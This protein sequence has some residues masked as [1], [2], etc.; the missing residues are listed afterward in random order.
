M[1]I[2]H[3]FYLGEYNDALFRQDLSQELICVSDWNDASVATE[4]TVS[5][6]GDVV[7]IAGYL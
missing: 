7:V 3:F 6:T 4:K 1:P 2:L 5:R